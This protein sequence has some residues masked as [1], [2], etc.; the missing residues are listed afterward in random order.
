MFKSLI[1]ASAAT[2]ALLPIVTHAQDAASTR[3]AYGVVR[4]GVGVDA[5]VKL[6]TADQ[7]APSSFR[8]SAD[9]KRGW[10]GDLGL[11]Y[12][13]RG[14]RL[15]ATAGLARNS[16]DRSSTA[17]AAAFDV[18]GRLKKLDFML[19]GYVDLVPNGS[20]SPFVGAGIGMARISTKLQ[21]TAGMIG[22]TVLNDKDW[23]FSWQAAAG[24]AVKLGERSVVDFG[25][26]HQRV[27]G[28][29]LDGQVNTPATGRSFNTD[30]YRATSA[31]VGL[32]FGF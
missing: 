9:A 5:D 6:K 25:V 1:A 31:L 27:S 21:R 29:R 2:L 30:G 17:K 10:T 13:L 15:E 11:G 20:V 23:G 4:M 18:G 14:F 32:R 26:K 7:A 28:I 8:A 24:V 16:I 22:G 19:S 12:D 3:G